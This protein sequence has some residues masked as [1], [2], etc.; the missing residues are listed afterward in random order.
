MGNAIV[1]IFMKH[2]VMIRMLG[3]SLDLTFSLDLLPLVQHH[4]FN[5][6]I[7]LP[8]SLFVVHWPCRG[9]AAA[10]VRLRYIENNMWLVVSQFGT[11]RYG[12]AVQFSSVKGKRLWEEEL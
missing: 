11:V 2:Y 6:F 8:L 5:S 4:L 3:F 12:S 1:V 9:T 10:A 7:T